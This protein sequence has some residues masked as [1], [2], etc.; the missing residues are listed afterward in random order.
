VTLN[1]NTASERNNDRFE[2]ERDG[3]VVAAVPTQGNSSNRHS[4]SWTDTQLS[5]GQTYRYTLFSVATNGQRAELQR[6]NAAPHASTPAELTEY[7]LYPNFPNP[8]NAT[9]QIRFDVPLTSSVRLAMYDI[10]GRLVETL[11]SRVFDAGPHTVTFDGEGK[12]AGIY[13]LR[14]TSGD[15][16]AV[17][18]VVL[19]K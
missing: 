13:F 11:A 1:W 6:L 17:Q 7:A 10:E 2:I 14:M 3:W 18:K 19:I 9:T 8:F 16:S 5:N 12:S 15:F 4:Y